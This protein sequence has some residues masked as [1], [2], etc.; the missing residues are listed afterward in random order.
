MSE[1][2]SDIPNQQ[3]LP[4]PVHAIE[5]TPTL[6][7]D[8]AGE[9]PPAQSGLAEATNVQDNWARQKPDVPIFR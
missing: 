4:E 1:P 9:L 6:T 7:V 8:E 2:T 3:S 5:T